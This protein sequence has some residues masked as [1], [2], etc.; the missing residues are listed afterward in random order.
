MIAI[1]TLIAAAVVFS[2]SSLEL[3]VRYSEL[4]GVPGATGYTAFCGR[5]CARE[6]HKGP[7]PTHMY[8]AGATYTVRDRFGVYGDFG[9]TR[10]VELV[11][12]S[13]SPV[14]KGVSSVHSA[15]DF[16]ML[17]F[18]GFVTKQAGLARPYAYAGAGIVKDGYS[19]STK[20]VRSS[21][22]GFP[23]F[24]TTTD[25]GPSSES[26]RG[27][28]QFGAGLRLYAGKRQGV[29]VFGE[30]NAPFRGL[31]EVVVDQD[32]QNALTKRFLRFGIGYFFQWRR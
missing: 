29:Q 15:R 4:I 3:N 12:S 14:S 24:F 2:S 30:F 26:T 1:H 32:R 18:G 28:F 17:N 5:V 10:R 19:W 7:A 6:I 27:N 13:T 11:T 21:G 16:K 23:D 9:M 22:I 20:V 8:G 31:E 25:V